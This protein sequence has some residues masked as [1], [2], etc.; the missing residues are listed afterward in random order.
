M[1]NTR[2]AFL[3]MT[4]ILAMSFASLTT[5]SAQELDPEQYPT[6]IIQPG[7]TLASIAYRFGLSIDDLIQINNIENPNA[8]PIGAEIILPGMEGITGV[9]TTMP[10]SLGDSLH[11]FSI[12]YAIPSEDLIRINKLSSMSELYAGSNL[13]L[14]I[15][16]NGQISIWQIGQ[17]PFQTPLELA[18]LGNLN[19]WQLNQQN[20]KTNSWDYP[21]GQ[22]VF[23]RSMQETDSPQ[24]SFDWSLSVTP[25]ELFQGD[26]AVIRLNTNMPMTT[27]HGILGEHDLH[28]FEEEP[29][30]YTAYQGIHAQEA[31]GLLVLNVSGNEAD[32]SVFSHEQMVLIKDS[33]YPSESLFVDPITID[34]D[35]MDAEQQMI[36]EKISAATPVKY[37]GDAFQCVVDQ[38]VCIRSWF[39]TNRSYNDG[40]YYNF[41]SGID[42]GVC[43]SLNIYAPADGV[44]TYTGSLTVRGNTTYIDHGW[45]VYSGFFHQ[46]QIL[47]EEGESVTAGQLIGQI[48]ASGRV[49]GAHLHYEIIANGVHIN[50]LQWLDGNCR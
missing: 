12:E 21:T 4:L 42:Y 20:Q 27:L 46:D 34:P 44:V 48:G 13:I 19:L 5:V 9:L 7:D 38:P 6:Y 11:R 29:G 17:V 24:Y 49:T 28:F 10:V 30:I 37:F 36:L 32:Q 50:P 41:H 45:G 8:I 22:P 2:M 43:A 18:V 31:P 35:T 16:D 3:L 33:S 14:P 1:K 40:L 25:D 15:S 26:V 47:V 39:G 23:I